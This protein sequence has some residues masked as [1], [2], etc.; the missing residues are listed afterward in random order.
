MR[1]Q[2]LAVS[3]KSGDS[4]AEPS[5]WLIDT[6]LLEIQHPRIRLLGLRLTQL[7]HR[8]EDKALA[9]F[10]HVQNLP[11]GCLG[12]GTGVPALTVLQ[13]GRGDCHTKSTLLVALLRSVG[14][15]SRLRFF[16]MPSG[17]LRGIIDLEGMP[18]QH[19][20]VEMQ[21]QRR[22]VAVDTH[23]VDPPL[24]RVALARLRAEG[25]KV[26]YGMHVDGQTSWDGQQPAFAQFS[27]RDPASMPSRDWGAFDD[28][29]QFYSS[30][31]AVQERLGLAARLRWSVGARRVNRRVAELR[32]DTPT[33][34]A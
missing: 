33:S 31:P 3:P 4:E 7:K 5:R 19:C 24:A 10:L 9:C 22:W 11:F 26:G 1:E 30:V 25:L 14:I 15:P 6:P 34:N 27:D 16:T 23:V 20:C 29:Y 8:P 32:A 2:A 21:V 28:P 17:F 18:I 13:R 12:D